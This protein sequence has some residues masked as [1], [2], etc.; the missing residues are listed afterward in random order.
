MHRS[1]NLQRLLIMG[2]SGPILALNI[3]LIT[4]VF[5]Y[6]EHLITLLVTAAILA[7][8]LNY[9]VQFFERARITR[10][11]AVTIVLFVTFALLVILGGTLVPIV[12]QQSTQL[13]ERIPTWL[14][15]SLRN[16]QY[17]DVW[18]RERNLP[19]D[20]KS[21]SDRINTQ[22]ESQIQTLASQALGFA[23]GTLSGLVDSILVLVLA[24][25]MLL[26]GKRLWQGLVNLLPPQLG[27]PLSQSLRL[28]FQNFFISQLLLAIIMAIAL[29]PIFLWLKVPFALLFALLIGIAELIPFIGATLGIG[30]VTLLVLLQ[31]PGLAV[32]VAISATILQQIRDNVLAPRM[33]GGFTGLNPIWIL[34]ALLVGL[35]IAGFLGVIIAVPIAGTIKDTLDAIRGTSQSPFLTRSQSET[36][37]DE[38]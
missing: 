4:Q 29:I 1:P 2:L 20:I 16:M 14:E 13:L 3:W 21:F 23:L 22:L 7:F 25:Y 26:Y 28:N 30:M 19:L 35:Q 38:G 18:A 9:L 6:F 37:T 32:Q 34:V 5:R 11:Q 27:G 24:F 8:L 17:L 31:D 10:T 12:I 33:M 36:T 15:A